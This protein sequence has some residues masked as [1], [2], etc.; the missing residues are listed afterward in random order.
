MGIFTYDIAYSLSKCVGDKIDYSLYPP[1]KCI[2]HQ[3]M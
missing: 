1:V 2:T 3:S